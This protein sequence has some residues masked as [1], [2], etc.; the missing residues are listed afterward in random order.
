MQIQKIG[1]AVYNRIERNICK[2][3]EF[4]E[5]QAKKDCKKIL[6][7]DDAVDKEIDRYLK[8]YIRTGYAIKRIY[9]EIEELEAKAILPGKGMSDT[10]VQSSAKN[11][12][13]EVIVGIIDE[14]KELYKKLREYRHIRGEIKNAIATVKDD[15]L[16]EVLVYI[17]ICGY[18]FEQTAELIDCETT[19]VFRRR[20]AGLQ[21]VRESLKC[22]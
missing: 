20:D 7:G 13:E 2:I 3:A 15:K 1:R 22:N 9:A 16:S 5:G 6:Q 4:A 19:T 11:V 8:Q 12:M 21:K 10:S 14:E 17:Y 18:T